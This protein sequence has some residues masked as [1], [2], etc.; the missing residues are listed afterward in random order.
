MTTGLVSANQLIRQDVALT[1][2]VQVPWHTWL[3]HPT[4][5]TNVCSVVMLC[6]RPKQSPTMHHELEVLCMILL[7]CINICMSRRRPYCGLC[8]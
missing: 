3:A 7:H 4:H 2:R 8:V 6:T 5:G 1:Q